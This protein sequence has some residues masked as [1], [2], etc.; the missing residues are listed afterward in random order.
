MVSGFAVVLLS[1]GFEVVLLSSL[2][3]VFSVVFSAEGFVVFSADE[4]AVL[5]LDGSEVPVFELA[6]VSVLLKTE[7]IPSGPFLTALTPIT[8]TA[9]RTTARTAMATVPFLLFPVL[10][11]ISSSSEISS[12]SL[13]SEGAGAKLPLFLSSG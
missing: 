1:E 9:T 10:T 6:V 11:Y 4:G 8:M 5:S 2:A 3:V 7:R 13:S 12:G